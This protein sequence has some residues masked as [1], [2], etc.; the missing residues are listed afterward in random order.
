[1]IKDT[2]NDLCKHMTPLHPLFYLTKHLLKVPHIRK[3]GLTE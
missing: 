1:M 2:K 3:I